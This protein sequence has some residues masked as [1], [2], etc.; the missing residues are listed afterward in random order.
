MRA[1]LADLA[2]LAARF[3]ARLRAAGLAVGPD[4]SARF[5][6][7]VTLA[8]PVTTNELYWCA[9]VTLVSEPGELAAFDR[10]FH[11]V[12]VAPGRATSQ[13]PQPPPRAAYCCGSS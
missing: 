10:V 2:E 12:F 7:A 5:A 3:A 4:R 8:D 9:R 13:P 1:D 6:R 11:Q